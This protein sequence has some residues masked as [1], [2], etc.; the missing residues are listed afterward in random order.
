MRPKDQM[1]RNQQ[2]KHFFLIGQGPVRTRPVWTLSE[3]TSCLYLPSAVL[4]EGL[5][6]ECVN[7]STT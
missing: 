2:N 6:P 3:I 1:F 5:N 7:I 4:C